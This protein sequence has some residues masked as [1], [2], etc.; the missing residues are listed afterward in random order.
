MRAEPSEFSRESSVDVFHRLSRLFLFYAEDLMNK[1]NICSCC[2]PEI[3]FKQTMEMTEACRV[4]RIIQNITNA[5]CDAE[6]K[7]VKGELKILSVKKSLAF[8]FSTKN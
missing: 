7:K 2:K 1:E 8:D 4:Y 3:D 6:I 5:G